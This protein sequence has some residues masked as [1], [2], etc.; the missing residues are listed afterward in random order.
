MLIL[1]KDLHL[2]AEIFLWSLFIFLTTSKSWLYINLDLNVNNFIYLNFLALMVMKI[3]SI[4]EYAKYLISNNIK[5][6][7][8]YIYGSLFF[9]LI[10]NM[11]LEN[12]NVDVLSFLA[13]Y[14]LLRCS[15]L[16]PRN[17]KSFQSILYGVLICSSLAVSGIFIGVIEYFF[18]NTAYLYE[19]KDTPSAVQIFPFH[20]GGFQ[21]SYNQTAYIIIAGLGSI[22]FLSFSRRIEFFYGL[23][24]WTALFFTG[25]KIV[26]LFF[27][28]SLIIKLFSSKNILLT[29]ALVVIS[30]L[31]YLFFSHIV[32]IKAGEIVLSEKYFREL[33]LQAYDFDWY[34]SLFSWLKTESW[35]YF[36]YS[37]EL[38]TSMDGFQNYTGGY[39]PH[40]LL[41]SLIFLGGVIFA[42]LVYIRIIKSSYLN[43]K[44]GIKNQVFFPSLAI[45][46]FCEAIIWDAQHSIIFWIVIS[47]ALW[48]KNTE[49]II[50]TSV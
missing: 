22:R 26:L 27:L 10:S 32:F 36:I 35:N 41:A 11:R 47:L 34:L 38:S 8:T 7:D 19:I 40:F 43:F 2:S 18:S 20:F 42:A 14:A 30:S 21:E 37:K 44:Y 39:E 50:N 48:D 16:F 9:F 45:V 33:V 46:F 1:K 5:V 13:I 4:L 17:I 6:L 23:I 15:S 3:P 28:I 29:K 25:A 49:K 12:F 31:A 24:F